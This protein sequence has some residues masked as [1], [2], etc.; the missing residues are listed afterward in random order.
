MTRAP[1]R[2]RGRRRAPATA[3]E[4][5]DPN[6]AIT[7]V[8]ANDVRDAER[9]YRSHGQRIS[10]EEMGMLLQLQDDPRELE[11]V[12]KR[13]TVIEPDAPTP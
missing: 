6:M 3:D 9:F 4:G 12:S 10:P 8:R 2:D 1:T 5:L 11:R 13:W 7:E